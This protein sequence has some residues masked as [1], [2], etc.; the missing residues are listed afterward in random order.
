MGWNTKLFDG[1]WVPT[2]PNAKYIFHKIEYDHWAEFGGDLGTPGQGANDDCFA[3]SVLPIVEAGQALLVDGDYQIDNNLWL[4]PTPGHTLGHVC[5]RL[6]SG[7]GNAVFCGDLMHH[8]IQ[9]AYPDWNSR[10][11]ADPLRAR[12]TRHRFIDQHAETN[13]IVLPAHF[14]FPT[15]GVSSRWVPVFAS[16][17]FTIEPEFGC[18]FNDQG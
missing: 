10:F 3:D 14:A 9:S 18:Y 2:F 11:C 6:Q 12:L 17:V 5:L 8:P 13:T 4:E 15:A 7:S 1:R 16:R